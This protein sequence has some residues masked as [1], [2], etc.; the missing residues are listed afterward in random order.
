MLKENINDIMAFVAVAREGSFTKAAAQMGLS[1]SALSHNVR[2]LEERLGLRLLSRTT[3]RVSP[4]S[5]GRRLIAEIAPNLDEM[6]QSLQRMMEQRDTP[7]GT[8]RITA[9]DFAIA[10]A[11]W[12]RLKELL[13]DYPDIKI[14]LNNDYAFADLVTG[15]FDAG[16]RMGE[17]V[18]EGMIAVRIGPDFSMR[19][20][21][22]PAYFDQHGRP[23]APDDLTRHRCINLR[24][25]THG[26]LYPWE[27][28]KDGRE[29]NVRVSGQW[30]FNQI[31]GVL[32][33]AREGYGIAY[34]PSPMIE[35]DLA[36]GTLETVLTDWSP[37]F[38][39]YHLY[40]PSRRQ[41]S[42]TF[43]L[44]IEALRHRS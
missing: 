28:E 30:T 2:R 27:F 29:V 43:S 17:S 44:I 26:G 13:R 4:T 7:A 36:E 38:P 24:L 12:P 6:E 16:V 3:R 22:T 41:A 39:G 33:A 32:E 8:F 37:P 19:A 9:T 25:P 1:Q 31:T 15:D 14:E 40:Y 11:L 23:Q 34:V 21:A 10:T 35:A 18:S 20:V 5:A 42:P